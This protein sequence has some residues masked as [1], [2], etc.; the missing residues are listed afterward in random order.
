MQPDRS[1]F[2]QSTKL[3]A[4]MSN[5]HGRRA[6]LLELSTTLRKQKLDLLLYVPH[7][8]SQLFQLT[9][10]NS[11][12]AHR[13]RNESMPF[14]IGTDPSNGFD[15]R[16]Q[17]AQTFSIADEGAVEGQGFASCQELHASK[18]SSRRLKYLWQSIVVLRLNDSI[19][20]NA[21]LTYSRV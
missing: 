6:H 11:V 18:V 20:S 14:E 3:D 12:R 21:Q 17:I 13:I 5:E 1:Q 15:S 16:L 9:T 8:V 19:Y 7:T 4:L 10:D 2:P